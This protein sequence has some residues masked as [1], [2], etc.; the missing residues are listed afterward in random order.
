MVLEL[1]AGCWL[2]LL[3]GLLYLDWTALLL[4]CNGGSGAAERAQV[5][6][7]GSRN[8]GTAVGGK[9]VEARG[10]RGARERLLTARARRK[11]GPR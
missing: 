6:N 2:L 11:A 9:R 10:E 7:G 5:G 1:A 3:L 4:H 8:K